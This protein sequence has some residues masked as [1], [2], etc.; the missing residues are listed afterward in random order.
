MLK[1][2]PREIVI[3]DVHGM[4]P[5]L[6]RLLGKLQPTFD[7][8][9]IFAGDLFDKGPDGPGV[10][11]DV[12]ELSFAFKVTWVLGNHDWKHIRHGHKV[13]TDATAASDDVHHLGM[14]GAVDRSLT[15]QDRV[16]AKQAVAWHRLAGGQLVIHGGIHE[17]LE[18]VV[19][20]LPAP[21]GERDAPLK[22]MLVDSWYD[23]Y[24]GVVVLVRIIDGV[25]K[26]KDRVK[27]MS[28]DTVHLID[29]YLEKEK[30][31]RD[32]LQLVGIAAMFI[33]SKYE[34]IFAPECRSLVD[35]P[36]PLGLPS[37]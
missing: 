17:T 8:H 5:E 27:F 2:A 10:A 7:D 37:C 29:R 18:A 31:M 20:R 16:F 15:P 6:Q 4:R 35:S 12:R 13:E 9:L 3:G 1:S 14:L 26:L 34:E 30:V 33:A 19:H 32:K 22:A 11:Q 36:A 21:K 23:A 28:N 24:L 25:I